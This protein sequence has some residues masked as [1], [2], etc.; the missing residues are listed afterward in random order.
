MWHWILII[1]ALATG[2]FFMRTYIARLTKMRAQRIYVACSV[3]VALIMWSC[4][5]LLFTGYRMEI[6]L[7]QMLLCIALSW[8]FAPYN[9]RWSALL[10]SILFYIGQIWSANSAL[11]LYHGS[12]QELV[13][14]PHA[15]GFP[16]VC[17]L[18]TL[19]SVMVFSGIYAIARKIFG[20][21]VST[22]HKLKIWL[23]T[24]LLLQL[25]FITYGYF[26]N[27]TGEK[28]LTL[29]DAIMVEVCIAACSIV[30]YG[31][32]YKKYILA[33]QRSWKLQ[34]VESQL[35]TQA[36]YFEQMQHN[37]LHINQ[38]RHDLNNQLQAAYYLLDQGNTESVRQQLD[39]LKTSI[40]NKVGPRY[41]SNLM[42]DAVLSEKAEFCRKQNIPLE[43]S[44]TLPADLPIENVH[45]CSIFSNLLDN[46]IHAVQELPDC[47]EPIQLHSDVRQGVLVIRCVNVCQKAEK[48]KNED[49][50]RE[51]G[52]GLT[53]LQ[54]LAEKYQGRIETSSQDGCFVVTM[55]LQLIQETESV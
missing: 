53:I 37:I 44:V 48:R 15:E 11:M 52:L 45:L 3:A 7:L 16:L 20:F 2:E 42:V 31:V 22:E 5:N 1:L 17:W 47:T 19:I 39:A 33:E 40:T 6:S 21:G 46:G 26:C 23:I 41:C 24:P 4:A 13:V 55:L 9:M 25:L 28:K 36:M 12:M 51:H 54:Q 14:Q 29:S 34:Q 43:I 18:S 49:P 10:L 50:L 32:I 38:I 30:S 8:Y 35:E 27:Y